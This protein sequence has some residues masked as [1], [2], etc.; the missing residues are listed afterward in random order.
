MVHSGIKAEIEEVW[1]QHVLN[2]G[3]DLG[4]FSIDEIFNLQMVSLMREA[5]IRFHESIKT[6]K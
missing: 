2:E 6:N 4:S 5:I 1:D 3:S